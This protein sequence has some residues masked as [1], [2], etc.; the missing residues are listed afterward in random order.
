VIAFLNGVLH[1]S[2]ERRLGELRSHQ[3]SSLLLLV[4]L[5]PCVIRT[6]RRHHVSS[7]PDALQIGLMWSS[8]SVAFE[9]LFGH[10]VNKDSWSELLHAY[11]VLD[12]RLWLLDVLGIA[13]APAAARAWRI[14]RHLYSGAVG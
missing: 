8:A 7:L 5:F 6:E 3:V 2:Y 14:R 9:F 12:G 13:A 1:R 4:L 11:D 10:Y